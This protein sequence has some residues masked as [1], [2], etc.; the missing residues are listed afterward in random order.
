MYRKTLFAS[1][2]AAK[3][4]AEREK[5]RAAWRQHVGEA[6]PAAG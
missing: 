3:M 2:L 1:T 6:A 4:R 5:M